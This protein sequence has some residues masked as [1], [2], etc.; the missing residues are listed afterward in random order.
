MHIFNRALRL[1][2]ASC[3]L[4][5]VFTHSSYGSDQPTLPPG[6]VAQ[7]ASDFCSSVGQP[8]VLDNPIA[9]VIQNQSAV[10]F[11]NTDDG[12]QTTSPVKDRWH[13]KLR[14]VGSLA[15]VDI[16]V[17]DKT[18]VV[19]YY[20]Q[21][22]N[23]SHTPKSLLAGAPAADATTKEQVITTA[24]SALQASGV[25][26]FG[27]LV[28]SEAT[29]H[30][31]GADYAFW[32]VSWKRMSGEIPYRQQGANVEIDAQTGSLIGISVNYKTAAATG[33]VQRVTPEQAITVA[34]QKL[35]ASGIDLIAPPTVTEQLV[36]PN[37][38]WLEP[39]GE[40]V[41]SPEV[42][43]AWVCLFPQARG[44]I[45]IWIDTETGQVIGGSLNGGSR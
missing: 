15:H 41:M 12:R 3:C 26:K 28:F 34:R 30:Q 16:D 36:Q 6:R 39:G 29:R 45:E 23:L 9:P 18:A 22:S 2:L 42:R 35:Q 31:S 33:V 25:L 1:T 5:A 14:S 21:P 40:Q 37:A 13:V 27:D 4:L 17:D 11:G 43:A 8:A 24:T 38:Y 44:D 7:I 10:Q 19:M 20:F 32:N